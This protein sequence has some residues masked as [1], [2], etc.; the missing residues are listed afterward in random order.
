LARHVR[1]PTPVTLHLKVLGAAFTAAFV[2]T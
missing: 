2:S 1:L